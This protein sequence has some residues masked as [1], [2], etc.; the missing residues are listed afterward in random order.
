MRLILNSFLQ[1][2]QGSISGNTSFTHFPSP[3]SHWP[4]TSH[5]R[6]FWL[7]H[8]LF[9]ILPMWA[10]LCHIIFSKDLD[11]QCMSLRQSHA[12]HWPTPTLTAWLLHRTVND[13]KSLWLAPRKAPTCVVPSTAWPPLL[14]TFMPL[15]PQSDPSDP[16]S[17]YDIMQ[18]VD[19][20]GGDAR[21]QSLPSKLYLSAF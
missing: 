5:L 11:R 10:H 4:L 15:W 7:L 8:S 17:I 1:G 21:P 9:L 12:S 14:F 18:N 2:D 6:L 13:S 16:W 19:L 20:S 3:R